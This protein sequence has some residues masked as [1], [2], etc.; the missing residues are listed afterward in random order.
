MHVSIYDHKSV[1]TTEGFLMPKNCKNPIEAKASNNPTKLHLYSKEKPHKKTRYKIPNECLTA[2]EVK[3]F[4]DCI[5]V[6]YNAGFELNRFMTFHIDPHCNKRK[7]NQF[8]IDILEHARKW[9]KQRGLPVAYLYVLENAPIKGIHA[10]VLI[11][12]PSG[13]QWNFRRALKRWIPFN[14][15][16][17]YFDTQTIKYPFYGSLHD[18]SAIYGVIK[19]MSK[20][21]NAETPIADIIPSYQGKIWGKRWGM[22][23]SLRK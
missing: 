20:G 5:H 12:I 21:L 16:K 11:H 23:N 10:H 14:L 13:E 8:I 4:L 6:A 2:K 1:L 7:P 19:Y 17:P 15:I 18:K 22:S 9:L 3:R